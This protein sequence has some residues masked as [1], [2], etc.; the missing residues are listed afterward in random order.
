[1]TDLVAS[2]VAYSAFTDE[3]GVAE[4]Y[5]VFGGIFLPSPQVDATERVLEE[6]CK[7]RVFTDREMSWKKCSSSKCDRY[8]AFA[9]LL[10]DLNKSAAPV[11]FRAM[12]VD[13]SSNPLRN[14]TFKC[15]TKEDG[16]YKFYHFFITGGFRNIAVKAR[17]FNV[18]VATLP[19]QYPFRTEVLGSTVAGSLKNLFGAETTVRLVTRADPLQKRLH[20]LADVLLGAVS[21][22]Y[23]RFDPK[24]HKAQITRALE[25]RTG[26]NLRADYRPRERPFNVWAFGPKGS[27]RWAPGARGRI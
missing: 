18:V 15:L 26:R 3:S 23:N 4:R 11:D 20:Q 27:K 25:A 14:P 5:L 9:T 19:D 8:R 10:W 12:V 1:M 6:F 13:T 17:T 22:K 2:P 24:S 21:F 16:F 7:R